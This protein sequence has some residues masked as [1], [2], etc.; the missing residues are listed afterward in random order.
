MDLTLLTNEK[1]PEVDKTAVMDC[2][3][4]R[5]GVWEVSDFL[6]DEG[7]PLCALSKTC[8][9][10]NKKKISRACKFSALLG[11]SVNTQHILS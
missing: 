2:A 5:I 1:F 9:P 4:I 7:F 6:K 3:V 8:S 11:A 10:M